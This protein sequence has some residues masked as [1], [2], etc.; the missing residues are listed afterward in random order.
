[1]G[2][3]M[4]EKSIWASSA[5]CLAAFILGVP[6]QLVEP[7]LETGMFLKLYEQALSTQLVLFCIPVVSVLPVGAVF[8]KEAQNGFIRFYIT[9]IGRIE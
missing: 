9:R 7:P 1:M 5:A 6:F 8:V 2:E 4:R 3:L